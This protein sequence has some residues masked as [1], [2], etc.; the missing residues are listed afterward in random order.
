MHH[1]LLTFIFISSLRTLKRNILNHLSI[2][3]NEGGILRKIKRH[4]YTRLLK[5]CISNKKYRYYAYAR[6]L[7]IFNK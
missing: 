2:E 5:E 6:I 1:T 4:R 3:H 7:H